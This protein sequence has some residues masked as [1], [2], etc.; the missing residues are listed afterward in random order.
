MPE[1]SELKVVVITADQIGSRQDSDRVPDALAATRKLRLGDG[2]RKF[3]R[4]AGDEIQGMVTD[5]DAAIRVIEEL[6]RLGGWRI[7]VGVGAVVRP[8]PRDVRAATGDAFVA[9]R[10]ALVA[11]HSAPQ[12]LRVSGDDTEAAADLEAA[13]WLLCALWRRRTDT[14]WETVAAAAAGRQ[15]QQ[16]ARSL[17]ITPSAVSQRLRASAY[18]EAKAGIRLAVRLL[19]RSLSV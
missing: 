7:G 18:P 14:G 1:S 13:L 6:T 3:A 11:A 19:Q 5:A 8:V 15:Q 4:T 17:G 16:I 2:A 9:A 10:E 12:D